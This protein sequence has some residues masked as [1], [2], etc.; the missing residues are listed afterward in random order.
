MDAAVLKKLAARYHHD[1]DL[2][3]NEEQTKQS[4]GASAVASAVPWRTGCR[5]A[6]SPSARCLRGDDLDL[7][8]RPRR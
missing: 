4:R 2:I 3:R 7:V 5:I 1:R 6:S 8:P